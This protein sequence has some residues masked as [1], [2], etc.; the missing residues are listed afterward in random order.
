MTA[1]RFWML[2]L[3]AVALVAGQ[4]PDRP[5]QNAGLQIDD[6]D[7]ALS[8][9]VCR[10]AMFAQQSGDM[11]GAEKLIRHGLT[12]FVR[13]NSLETTGGAAC[14][15]TFA[16]LLESRSHEN[17]A[18]EQLEHALAIREQLLGQNHFLVADTL[19][20]LGLTHS[21]QGH[22]A[23]A[24]AIQT[25]AV[26]IL[27]M[28]GPSAELAAALNNLGDVM[29][30]QSR[31][32]EAEIR[33]REA[34]S[35]WEKAGGPDDPSVAAGLLN[36]GVLLE[37]RKQYDEAARVLARASRIDEKTFSANHPRIAMNLNAAGVLATA[38]K[39]YQE[40][41]D[42]LA[43]AASILEGLQSPQHAETGQ[44]LLNL[45]EVYRLEKKMDQARDTYRRGLAGVTSAWGPNDA[46]LPQWMEKL[47]AVLREQQDFAG[48]EEL[49]IRATRIRVTHSIR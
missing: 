35:I 21:R 37:E 2:I 42:L 33:I 24:E 14:L 20:R 12:L 41:E 7:P 25:R 18:Q 27:R 28:Q 16:S 11:P 46:R 6:T 13:N 10:A 17:E 30:A 4:V 8:G 5:N 15:T 45:A 3:S 26:N 40:A 23:E 44:V 48:A 43:R 22:L 47:A 34:I 32:K 38:R 49:E 29:S 1:S 9:L 31:W 19:V 36:L 39:K